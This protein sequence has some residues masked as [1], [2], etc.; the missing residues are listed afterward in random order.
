MINRFKAIIF[1][2]DGVIINSEELHAKAKK[3]ILNRFGIEYPAG[4]FN[5]FKGRPDLA[6]WEHVSV[7]LS[8]GKYKT[9]ELDAAKRKVFFSLFSDLH[10]VPGALDFVNKARSMFGSTALVTSAANADLMASEEKFGLKKWFD[11]IQTGDDTQNH[12]PH[13]EPYQKA[14]E[15]LHVKPSDTVV[16]E[17]SPNGVN[18]AK[19]A[20]CFVLGI[21]TGFSGTELAEAG[22]DG[23]F[24]SFDAITRFLT[25]PPSEDHLSRKKGPYHS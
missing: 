8:K 17:D 14:L 7:V 3:I 6:F 19:A 22:A 2:L 13:P 16:I 5:D 25:G 18:A 1:D 23:V 15:K 12:K 10:P 24:E 20:G 9:V 11:V 21:T 4:I